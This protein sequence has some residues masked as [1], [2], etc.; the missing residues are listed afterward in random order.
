MT[1]KIKNITIRNFLSV[2]NVVQSVNLDEASLS[3]V[4]GNNMDLGG[5]GARNGVGKSSLINAISY[6]LYGKSLSNIKLDNMINHTNKKGMIVTVDFEKNSDTY[7]IERGRK[8]NIFK[9]YVNNNEVNEK[10]TDEVQGEGKHTQEEIERILGLSHNLFKHIV[11]L[12]TYNE[13]FLSLRISDQREIIEELLGITQLSEKAVTLKEVIRSTKDRITEEEYRIKGVENANK[14]ITDSIKNLELKSKGWETRKQKS[15]NEYLE[16]LNELQKIDID[17]ELGNHKTLAEIEDKTAKVAD[18]QRWIDSIKTDD[19]KQERLIDKIN[20]EVLQLESHQ[21]YACGQE[22]H[23]EKQSEILS[24]KQE[25]LKEARIH[26]D[27]NS[28]QLQEHVA[29]IELIG[30]IPEKPRVYYKNVEQALDHRNTVSSLEQQIK[31]KEEE[32]NPFHD[33]IESLTNDGIQEISY[34]LINELTNLKEHQ[35][36]LLKLL[37]NKDSFIRKKIIQQNLAYLNHRLEHYLN[38]LGLPHDVSFQPDLSVEIQELGRDLD[39]HNLSR[40]ERNRLILG[41]SWAFRDIFESMN[42]P[43][44]LLCIDELIDNGLDTNGVESAMITLKKMERERSKD[45]FLVSHREE[46]IGRVSNT[47]MVSKINGFTEFSVG[48]E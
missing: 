44:N 9:F 27:S 46:L 15:I 12:N 33:Q 21:C 48:D 5:D 23:D 34:E 39:F 2:G 1:I 32:E 8:P 38:E 24:S 45:I 20:K 11:T 6:A 10:D 35:E 43:I 47:L 3:L 7:R 40:G 31:T 26:L 4:L 13:P 36:F 22:L 28:R 41:L 29:T 30:D 18:A 37:T 25:I 16:A 17:T 42:H 14:Q 19:K